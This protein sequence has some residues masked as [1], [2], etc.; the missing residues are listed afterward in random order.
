MTTTNFQMVSTLNNVVGNAATGNWSDAEKQLKLIQEE[1]S[2]LVEGVE[3]KNIQEV[4]DAIADVL[5]T[6]YGMAHR[7]GIDADADMVVV[8]ASN[9]SKFDTSYCDALQSQTKYTDMGV[10]TEIF[11]TT[12]EIDGREQ[13]LYIIK[14]S[15]EQLFNG[16]TIPKGKFL[17]SDN[18]FEPDLTEEGD[19]RRA[20]AEAAAKEKADAQLEK[21]HCSPQTM[22]TA[23][24]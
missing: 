20:E 6:T 15:R 22:I 18:F 5:V 19:L 21:R 3:N 14:S 8:D 11:P 16:K 12:V 7:M 17:K 9:M 24:W 1:M 23:G 13:D 10:E 2:E 4:R